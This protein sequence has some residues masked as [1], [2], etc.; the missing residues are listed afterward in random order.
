MVMS[1]Y[2]FIGTILAVS[3][4]F[5]CFTVFSQPKPSLMPNTPEAMSLIR[6]VDHPVSLSSGIP[7]ITIPL[8]VLHSG[9]LG[10]PISLSYQG[11][12]FKANEQEGVAGLG[13]NLSTDLQIT[14]ILN[15]LDDFTK[16][17]S[18]Y[19]S[20]YAHEKLTAL[21]NSSEYKQAYE[22]HLRGK[23][24]KE[25]DRFYY[26][27]LSGR[28]GTFYIIN[29]CPKVSNKYTRHI[30]I[31]QNPYT[32]V[33]IEL[34]Y[35]PLGFQSGRF[36]ITDL[37]GTQYYYGTM[38][39]ARYST[40]CELNSEPVF[41]YSSA[42]SAYICAWKCVKIVSPNKK[43]SIRLDYMQSESTYSLSTKEQIV[44]H[45]DKNTTERYRKYAE[46]TEEEILKAIEFANNSYYQKGILEDEITNYISLK[47]GNGQG[48]RLFEEGYKKYSIHLNNGQLNT[49]VSAKSPFN[50]ALY[51]TKHLAGNG[52][53]IVIPTKNGD[54]FEIFDE[55]LRAPISIHRQRRSKLSSIWL[56]HSL[57]RFTYGDWGQLK[58]I[59]ISK[60]LPNQSNYWVEPI[61]V[62]DFIQE[63]Y[64]E[65]SR[66]T[67]DTYSSYYEY[68][69][70]YLK[71]VIV[72]SQEDSLP[73]S[74]QYLNH[75]VF[76]NYE[77]PLNRWGETEESRNTIESLP[78]MEWMLIDKDEY[79]T[80]GIHSI[81]KSF[82]LAPDL[83]RLHASGMVDLS[84]NYEFMR[85]KSFWITDTRTPL[86]GM[87]NM[88]T[89]P[90]GAQ[91]VF[92]WE[93]NSFHTLN[94]AYDASLDK[95]SLKKGFQEAGG[96]RINTIAH[97]N[98][99][100]EVHYRRF[101]YGK[102][103]SGHGVLKPFIKDAPPA[104]SSWP[105]SIANAPYFPIRPGYTQKDII[106][107]PMWLTYAEHM[108]WNYCEEATREVAV[109]LVKTIPSSIP[110]KFFYDAYEALLSNSSLRGLLNSGFYQNSSQTVEY[111]SSTVWCGVKTEGTRTF[112][113][114][115]YQNQP[116][117]LAAPV[118][119]EEVTEYTFQSYWSSCTGKTIYTYNTPTQ[120]GT[121]REYANSL[122]G[123]YSPHSDALTGHLVSKIEYE[124]LHLPG[125][126]MLNDRFFKP[127]RSTYHKY[128]FH[129]R[130]T[131]PL[132]QRFF[133]QRGSVPYESNATGEPKASFLFN[134]LFPE[135]GG[136]IRP[137]NALLSSSSITTHT[138][139][140]DIKET[141]DYKFYD[142]EVL[143]PLKMTIR[144]SAGHMAGDTKEI[145]THYSNK[146][147][148][149][150]K[151]HR[152][153]DP[154]E[155]SIEINEELQLR[156]K[157]IYSNSWLNDNSLLAL[158]KIQWAH[159]DAALKDEIVY[160]SY[161]SH[162]NPTET[163][164]VGD[165][166]TVYHWGHKGTQPLAMFKNYTHTLLLTNTELHS[167]L[168]LLENYQKITDTN[169]SSLKNLNEAIRNSLAADILITTYTYDPLV[170]MT[171]H[172]N[173][174]GITTYY[175]YDSL[176]RL[177][178][179][180]D[181]QGN[182]LNHYQYH[183][184]KNP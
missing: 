7:N 108:N 146:D 128:N 9:S 73:Y 79:N 94:K 119:Y 23:A 71:Q 58:T 153:I 168:Q 101:C 145:T 82:A 57:V 83:Y 123:L 89:Y 50:T 175:E 48:I 135:L 80:M 109:P 163:S 12:G 148:L 10:F 147:P 19:G 78:A 63:L 164:R 88:I 37:D 32:G 45:Y 99:L 181:H 40:N 15:G 5:L 112:F 137:Y 90:S 18:G 105:N 159:G 130:P 74:F 85:G 120:F 139:S 141:V 17:E 28:S 39:D 144:G 179:I 61:K 95:W 30:E 124:C 132:N 26:S 184:R 52:S 121:Q 13:W 122:R 142:H 134:Y 29:T 155:R 114:N 44:L 56:K 127:V 170:G 98:S 6:S 36:R 138:A 152:W 97:V 157:Y 49:L 4:N 165:Y 62:I 167:L 59:T 151:E 173:P 115:S 24:D 100:G 3:F 2:S 103:R 156:E 31:H 86:A 72:S 171:S 169:R 34:L 182:I 87:L 84:K 33:K 177:T 172:T 106:N 51:Y 77:K 126:N 117:S 60:A 91:D 118:Y 113:Y 70:S 176:G 93:R 140:Q 158:E 16:G 41:D 92:T 178:Y 111:S 25:P 162:G 129:A 42:E 180:K 81:K 11:G 21:E 20:Y 47:D 8:H 67:S 68:S 1:K 54:Y 38:E 64:Q 27:L 104:H 183:Y 131:I 35:A 154:V 166:S 43:D 160:H 143:L 75:T 66:P 22:I 107:N 102:G 65:K 133:T 174:N 14:R 53:S 161:D 136:Q 150:R 69:T 110:N 116:F 125:F 55:N 149:M 46:L 76:T 96:C